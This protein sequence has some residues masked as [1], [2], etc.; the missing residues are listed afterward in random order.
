MA[1]QTVDQPITTREARKKLLMR[2]A[3]YWKAIDI[4][5]GV[6]YRSAK[7]GGHWFARVWIEERKSYAS[8]A[9]GRADDQ[10][11]ADG[12]TILDYRQAAEKAKAWASRQHF[13][14]AGLNPDQD[15]GK[16]YT[17]A[18]AMDDYLDA[19]KRRGG[20][21]PNE[22]RR[23][24]DTHIK[25]KIGEVRLEKLTRNR[26]T[27]WL[28]SL[29]DSPSR[30]RTSKKATAPRF[31]TVDPSDTDALRRRRATSNRILTVLKAALNHARAQGA[32]HGSDDAWAMVKPFKA[33]DAPKIRYLH[34]AECQRLVAAC[35]DDF[36]SL[37]TAALLTGMRY[38]ELAVMKTKDFNP[39]EGS[40]SVPI[41][42]SGKPRLVHLDDDGRAFFAQTT[43][44]RAAGLLVFTHDGGGA[45]G[46]SHQHRPLQAACNKAEIAPA[47]SFHILRHTYASR[48]VTKGVQMEIIAAQLGHADT[49]ITARHY[50]HLSPSYIADTIRTA[51]TSMGIVPKSN[52]TFLVK[53]AADNKN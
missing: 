30:L 22:T 8:H 43:A 45:W 40:I 24:I 37:V 21:S 1:R 44:G 51:S 41:S 20:K 46:S 14:D 2:K 7:D 5:A 16:R 12:Q 47:I 19:F 32:F 52:V 6:G 39:G 53:R 28:D 3:P 29:A 31:K 26:I 42:K 15:T 13:V 50:A 10:L 18:N 34:D 4:G 38:G 9:V 17:V 23:A 11:K 35:P 33:V 25:P 36:R 49:R 48:L 27:A